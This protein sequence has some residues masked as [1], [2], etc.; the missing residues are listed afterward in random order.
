[1][2]LVREASL[3]YATAKTDT[4]SPQ[5]ADREGGV[6]IGHVRTEAGAWGRIAIA[7][8]ALEALRQSG[9]LGPYVE[10]T[11]RLEAADAVAREIEKARLR[12]S[13]TGGYL[14]RTPGSAGIDLKAEARE[15]RARMKLDHWAR[16]VGHPAM[17]LL[18]DTLG[19]G[20]PVPPRRVQELARALD[21]IA[22]DLRL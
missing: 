11:R 8:G 13:T 16:L 7:V 15:E 19:L 3:L 4:G 18:L 17:N 22:T 5:R 10:A 21:R 1:M 6:R 9:A 12:R 2:T 20:Q 14:L